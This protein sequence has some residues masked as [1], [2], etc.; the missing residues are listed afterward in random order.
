MGLSSRCPS[1]ARQDEVAREPAQTAFRVG[2]ELASLRGG[3]EA[4]RRK[5]AAAALRGLRRLLGSETLSAH[6]NSLE[7]APPKCLPRKDFLE[8]IRKLERELVSRLDPSALALGRWAEA[9][10]LAA[11]SRDR[12]FFAEPYFRRMFSDLD[13]HRFPEIVERSLREIRD[14]VAASRSS[15]KELERALRRLIRLF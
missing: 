7:G 8:E 10:R 13:D 14:A 6:L 4:G 3:I 9:S 5:D 2:V 1:A 12:R 11:A 15:L